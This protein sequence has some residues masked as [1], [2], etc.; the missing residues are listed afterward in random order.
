[1]TDPLEQPFDAD[2]NLTDQAYKNLFVAL[3]MRLGGTVH[4][5]YAELQASNNREWEYQRGPTGLTIVL[6][7]PQEGTA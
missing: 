5:S 7:Q 3:L 4:L 2:G 6:V 1:M